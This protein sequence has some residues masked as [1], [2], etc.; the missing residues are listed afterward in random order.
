MLRSVNVG[1]HYSKHWVESQ[2]TGS[3]NKVESV[4]EKYLRS[5]SVRNEGNALQD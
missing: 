5:Y 1:P 4:T 2:E 3:D